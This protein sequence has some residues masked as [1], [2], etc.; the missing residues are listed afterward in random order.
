MR[1]LSDILNKY[2]PLSIGWSFFFLKIGE[3][4][5]ESVESSS[6]TWILYLFL[7]Q[8][9][10]LYYKFQLLFCNIKIWNLLL[11]F[12]TSVAS[13]LSSDNDV[14]S[15]AFFLFS[16]AKLISSVRWVINYNKLKNLKNCGKYKQNTWFIEN[17]NYFMCCP[18]FVRFSFLV[19][20][21]QNLWR[22]H[23]RWPK[24]VFI[25]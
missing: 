12:S 19:D 18:I 5:L 8:W 25:F 9:K 20:C 17:F 10:I 16:L 3:I 11:F 7:K 21:L 13:E 22:L 15:S 4:S 6:G 23:F 1:K 14:I 2:I 24:T